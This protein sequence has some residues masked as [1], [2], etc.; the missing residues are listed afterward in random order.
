MAASTGAWG[1]TL[2]LVISSHLCNVDSLEP[3]FY[4][5]SCPLAEATVAAVVGTAVLEDRRVG[6]G[7]LRVFF[8]DCFVEGCDASIL[9][10]SPNHDA[11]KDALPN[12]TL[13]SFDVIDKAKA[14]VELLCGQTVS[15]ADI[16][17]FAAATSVA[18]LGGPIVDIHGGR[19]D[20][21]VSSINEPLNNIP[22]PLSSLSQLQTSFANKG[23]S[24][25]DLV[26]LS[27]A[28]TVGKAHCGAFSNRLR[29]FSA[30]SNED[31]SL[32]AGL[33]ASLQQQCPV[34]PP[35]TTVVN[36]DVE[37]PTYFDNGYYRDVAN[38][39]GLFTSDAQLYTSPSTQGIV[40]EFAAND[41]DFLGK[42]A[43][44][45]FRMGQ[46]GLKTAANGNIRSNCRSF[47]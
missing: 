43:D 1:F 45:L 15:C 34:N 6:A 20:G 39:E 18:L 42:F 13:H 7:L 8:H 29:N 46:I 2:L 28:H 22:S 36:N 25:E 24:L 31:P 30:T 35:S 5:A 12:L 41:F 40:N 14:D 47:S 32:D 4:G 37:T 33:A 23:L 26:I 27:G 19:F 44:S 11:E 3:N 16:L 38:R 17:A 21:L 9:I 10:D